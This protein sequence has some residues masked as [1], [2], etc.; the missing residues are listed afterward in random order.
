MN[1]D[2]EVVWSGGELLAPRPERRS[3]M[4]RNMLTEEEAHLVRVTLN[5]A[6]RIGED[7]VHTG[8]YCLCGC[9]EELVFRKRTT[10]Q[11][12]RKVRWRKGHSARVNNARK[13]TA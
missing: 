10:W 12:I 6:E 11:E 1:D 2:L 3:P 13:R 7:S 9:G 4:W 5:A 8:R